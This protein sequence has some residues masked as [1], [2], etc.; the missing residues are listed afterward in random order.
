[1]TSA[2]R[3]TIQPRLYATLPS[4]AKFVPGTSPDCAGPV[5]SGAC[6][7]VPAESTPPCAGATWHY[8]IGKDTSWSFVFRS[9]GCVCPAAVL[10]PLGMETSATRLKPRERRDRSPSLRA[11]DAVGRD[12]E[13]ARALS[14]AAA[15]LLSHPGDT[16]RAA[17]TIQ[18][19][20]GWSFERGR[21]FIQINRDHLSSATAR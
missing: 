3:V 15:S 8:P 4:G 2:D 18:S 7:R 12:G 10:D 13:V 11:Q 14:L 17:R 19:Q 6:S 1:M 21:W 5:A 16:E 20:L 9:G